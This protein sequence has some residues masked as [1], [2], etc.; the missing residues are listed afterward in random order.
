MQ[1]T[2][3]PF[4]TN[5]R[6]NQHGFTL[7]EIAIVMVIIGFL[8]GGVLVAQSM[9]RAEQIR[10]VVTESKNYQAAVHL[11]HDKYSAWPGDMPNA[12][13]IWGAVAVPASCAAT[14]STDQRT[15][16]GDGNGRIQTIAGS[17]E[18]SRLWQHLANAGLI[19]GRYNGTFGENSTP[20]SKLTPQYWSLG[21]QGTTSQTM[22]GGGAFVADGFHGNTLGLY[23]NYGKLTPREIWSIDTKVD[24]GKPMTGKVVVFGN[25]FFCANVSSS[26]D[27][28]GEYPLSSTTNWCNPLFRNVF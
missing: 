9:I 14:A 25:I 26:D 23:G 20:L 4:P 8:V 10:S 17:W 16:D 11:F 5:K 21:Y 18:T 19:E 13:D 24:D 3:L 1:S 6:L 2:R 22:F 27:Y 7:I 15:C 12:T 28:T